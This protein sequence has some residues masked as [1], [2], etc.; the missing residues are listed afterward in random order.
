M[1]KFF[2]ASGDASKDKR[3]LTLFEKEIL[4][5]QKQNGHVDQDKIIDLLNRSLS[6]AEY[7]VKPETID[8]PTAFHCS[9]TALRLMC[10]D[11]VS[12]WIPD[13]EIKNKAYRHVLKGLLSVSDFLGDGGLEFAHQVSEKLNVVKKERK[14][15]K[16][17]Q[18]T[19]DHEGARVEKG[20]TSP[21]ALPVVRQWTQKVSFL[22]IQHLQQTMH[23]L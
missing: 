3:V 11:T 6:Y 21:P 4:A 5:L 16:Q 18:Q 8:I 14:A 10:D 17:Q 13:A 2:Q 1:K 7:Y 15:L 23:K 9:R 19:Q 12:S 22:V 20:G